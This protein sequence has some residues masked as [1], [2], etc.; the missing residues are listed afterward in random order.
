MGKTDKKGKKK[1]KGKTPKPDPHELLLNSVVV[2]DLQV[3]KLAAIRDD[4]VKLS[5]GAENAEDEG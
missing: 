3:A 2:L 1:A 4:L 5:Q